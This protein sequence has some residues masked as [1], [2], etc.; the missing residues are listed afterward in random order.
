[1]GTGLGWTKTA[2][3]YYEVNTNLLSSG[4]DYSDLYY[5]L[6][7]ACTNLVG[8]KGITIGD[9][10]EVK[11]AVDAVEMNNQPTP[12]FNTDAPYCDPGEHD[13]SPFSDD[14]KIRNCELDIHERSLPSLASRSPYY[15]PYAQSG[16]HSLYADDYPAVI[17]DASAK[18]KSFVVPS[19][20]Y[21]HFAQAY[22]F[23]TSDAYYDGGVL[24]YGLNNGSTWTDAGALIE[25][26][27]YTGTL[28]TGAG[29]PLSGRSAFVGASHGYISTRLNLAVLGR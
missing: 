14:L 3:I 20:A 22:D 16:L 19:N 17:T 5:A 21:L 8:Q 6:Q 9:C 4:A 15:G 11:D 2:A 12:N 7:Q 29:N 28:F 23:E 27:G 1:M 18:L 25:F 13:D 24:E 10:V 26:N